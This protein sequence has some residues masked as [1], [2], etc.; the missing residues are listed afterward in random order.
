MIK[1]IE[2]YYKGFRF[3]S[4]LEARWAVFFDALGVRWEYEREGYALEKVHWK[5]FQGYET[6]TVNYLPDFYLPNVGDGCWVEIKGQGITK[7]ER[8]RIELLAYHTQKYVNVFIGN[9]GE[10]EVKGYRPLPPIPEKAHRLAIECIDAN[11]YDTYSY[12]IS[13]DKD[14]YCNVEVA[15]VAWDKRK[16]KNYGM[17][18]TYPR[19]T[20]RVICYCRECR[21]LSF[22]YSGHTICLSNSEICGICGES[23]WAPTGEHQTFP[24]LPRCFSCDSMDDSLM[25]NADLRSAYTAARSARFEH[26]EMP[27]ME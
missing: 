12:L 6:E 27:T 5:G 17:R 14:R 20:G 11:D 13:A 24:P 4:R 26:G 19:V 7:E 8:A 18:Y 16:W 15:K 25:G 10:Q 9:V 2:T 22:G 21:A 3:R 23:H 1:P